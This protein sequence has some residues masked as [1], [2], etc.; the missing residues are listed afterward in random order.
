MPFG[1]TETKKPNAAVTCLHCGTE[2]WFVKE[3]DLPEGFSLLCAK[4]GRR[5]IYSLAEV[6]IPKGS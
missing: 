5:K 3:P 6:H 2:I 1:M 4:C